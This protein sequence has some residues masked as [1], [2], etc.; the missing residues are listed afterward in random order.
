VFLLVDQSGSMFGCRTAGGAL[1]ATSKECATAPTRPGIPL[2][3]GVLKVVEQLGGDVRFGFAAFTG[4]VGDAMCPMMAPV[5]PRARQ[6]HRHLV[7]LQR[8]RRTEEGR[9]ARR[10]TRS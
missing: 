10:A 8:A 3:D 7:A 2:R 6:L 4:E 9:D 1:S 5:A